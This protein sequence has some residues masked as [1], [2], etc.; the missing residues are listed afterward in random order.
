M[1]PSSSKR[2][3]C[4]TA[5]G[6]TDLP[7]LNWAIRSTTETPKLALIARALPGGFWV[8]VCS[9]VNHV[10]TSVGQE[11][12]HKWDC[13]STSQHHISAELKV[14]RWKP[15]CVSKRESERV[16]SGGFFIPHAVERLKGMAS[17]KGYSFLLS[18]A[19]YPWLF[20]PFSR[21]T[22]QKKTVCLLCWDE[23]V[24][25]TKTNDYFYIVR[26]QILTEGMPLHNLLCWIWLHVSL[27]WGICKTENWN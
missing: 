21:K 4:E 7:P 6:L 15:A 1:N 16:E 24:Q 23:R 3:R 17:I 12:G 10:I 5:D 25:T 27:M 8:F 26:R 20:L 13:I 22:K 11:T 14:R 2:W 19:V 9:L 18:G